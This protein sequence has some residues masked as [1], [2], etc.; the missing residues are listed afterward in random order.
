MRVINQITSDIVSNDQHFR[1]KVKSV[2]APYM[3]KKPPHMS[4]LIED[5]KGSMESMDVQY[6]FLSD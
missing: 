4:L 3:L 5:F 1:L 6:H 2:S